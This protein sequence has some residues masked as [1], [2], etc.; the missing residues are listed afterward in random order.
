[1]HEAGKEPILA[2]EQYPYLNFPK[3]WEVKIIA[4]YPYAEVRFVVRKRGSLNLGISVYLDA[5]DSL[6][7]MGQPYWEIYPY[8]DGDTRRFLLGEEDK[9][10]RAIKF[11]LKSGA[12]V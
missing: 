11:A 10:L 9:L 5:T 12:S 3:S 6:G 2:L 7:S 4:P 1:M 8:C